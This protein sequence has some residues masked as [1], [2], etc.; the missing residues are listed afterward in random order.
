[1]G[2]FFG[3]IGVL[4][5]GIFTNPIFN[6]LMLL[7]RLFGD[8]GLSIVVLTLIIKLLLFP[9]TL[10]QLKSS[11]RMQDLQP[12]LQELRRKHSTDQQAQA[13]A[14]KELGIN[15]MAG[16]LP[17]LVQMPFLFGMY[18]AFSNV[19]RSN[20]LLHDINGLL[21]PFIPHFT[22]VN[23]NLNWFTWLKFLNPAWPWS[24]SL[25]VSD[26]TYILPVVAALATFVSIRMGLPKKVPD[27]RKTKP[28]QP[29]PTASSMKM[30]QYMMPGF[31]LYIGLISPAGLAL[32]WLVS[33]IFQAI[34]QYSVTG[35]GSLFE[36]PFKQESDGVTPSA[37][38]SGALAGRDRAITSHKESVKEKPP[39]E[40]EEDDKRVVAAATSGSVANKVRPTNGSRPSS[41]GSSSQS[42]SRRGRGSSASA[43]RRGSSR[44]RR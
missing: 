34:L 38:S 27:K 32:Y 7:Y 10:K 23:V 31:T 1:M 9:L 22:S 39:V 42:G 4:F 44:S 8:F 14:M 2:D 28:A 12:Q 30:M 43:R 40:D 6:A 17:M 11:K 26:P 19:L 21:Y 41:N 5:N 24:I 3:G 13:A 37:S 15:P 20:N 33:T 18:A 35:W 25:A 29:D 16:C 36:N